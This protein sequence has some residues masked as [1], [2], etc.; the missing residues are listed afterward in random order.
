MIMNKI[1]KL[2]MNNP[3]R[4]FLQKNVGAK[5]FLKIGGKR[6]INNALEVGCGNGTGAKIIFEVF[7][8]KHIDAF[9]LDSEMVELCKNNISRYSD[10]TRI[11]QGS[12]F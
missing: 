7:D 3:L 10:K 12:I 5:T 8:A 2:M 6:V 1:E 9:D 11:W 4:A